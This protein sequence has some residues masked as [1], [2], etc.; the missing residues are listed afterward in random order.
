MA[1]RTAI[2]TGVS[3]GLGLELALRLLT[4]DW[5]VIGVSRRESKNPVWRQ[6]V[7][8]GAAYQ[9]LG[10]VSEEGTAASAFGA[11][12]QLGN[13]RLL[14][15]CAGEGV[16]GPAGEYTAADVSDVLRGNL[17]GTILFCEEA[18]KRFKNN[19]G[20]IVN[21]LS[22]AALVPRSNESIYCA[23]KWGARGYTE[24]LRLEAKG[25]PVNVIAVYPGG[26]KTSFWSSAR[27]AKV[28]SSHFMAVGEVVDVIMNALKEKQGCYVSDITINRA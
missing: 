22:T 1:N 13:L 24:S 11:A 9:V 21:V 26:M 16:F 17:I 12:Q 23:S 27:G 14:V 15:N 2:V 25:T 6:H 28:D 20:K 10:D 4:E 5:R 8:S 19:G 3:S 7:Q 18:F